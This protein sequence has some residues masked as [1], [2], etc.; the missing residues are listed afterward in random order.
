MYH[1]NHHED[2]NMLEY[3]NFGVPMNISSSVS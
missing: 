2:I 3:N 1:E